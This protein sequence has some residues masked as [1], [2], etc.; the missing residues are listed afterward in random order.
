MPVKYNQNTNHLQ[1]KTLVQ[2]CRRYQ[3]LFLQETT[4]TDVISC[5]VAMVNVFDE[6]IFWGGQ[7][8]PDERLPGEVLV[9]C[10]SHHKTSPE[11]VFGGSF[12]HLQSKR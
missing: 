11:V 9:P 3:I 12:W 8:G 7:S 4:H 10:S 5:S 6:V 2:I 1:T